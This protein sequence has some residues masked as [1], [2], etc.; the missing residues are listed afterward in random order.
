MPDNLRLLQ[1]DISGNT[2]NVRGLNDPLWVTAAPQVQ[3]FCQSYTHDK[4]EELNVRLKQYL[5]LAPD[6]QYDVFIELWVDPKDLF[7][8]CVDP[9]NNDSQ[10]QTEVPTSF[11]TTTTSNKIPENYGQFYKNLYFKS[12]RG[13]GK[14][15][16][17]WTGLGYTYDWGND[18]SDIGASEFILMPNAPY[19]IER[20]LTTHEYCTK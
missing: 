15:R 3:G 2:K 16:A 7:R 18:D 8:P 6:W 12:F 11:P 19:Q 5:G 1:R 17:P 10:C 4:D 20:V 14:S 9:E 13:A